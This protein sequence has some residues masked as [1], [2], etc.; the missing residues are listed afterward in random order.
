MSDDAQVGVADIRSRIAVA[1][2]AALL[3][4]GLVLVMFVLPAEYGV[5]PLGTGARVGLVELGVVGQQ[6]AALEAAA[7]ETGTGAGQA[8]IIVP[9]ERGYQEE[10]VEF[11]VAAGEGM[12]YKYRLDQGEALLYS[13]TATGPVNYELHAEPDGAPQGYAQSYELRNGMSQASGTLTAPFSGIHG[14]FWENLSDE[15]ITV[16]LTAAGFYNLSH[17]FRTGL[18]VINKM[19]Q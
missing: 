9:Q 14:W 5:D 1:A 8:A 15:P 2:A 3:V 19:F 16:T 18:P 11:I 6:V 10:T 7:Q 4:A 13:W 17:E 12:E